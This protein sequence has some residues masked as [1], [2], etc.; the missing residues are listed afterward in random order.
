MV[1]AA[2]AL[3]LHIDLHR[4][5]TGIFL[6][7]DAFTQLSR[8]QR[9]KRTL[10]CRVAGHV[11]QIE[12]AIATGFVVLALGIALCKI[13]VRCER[14]WRQATCYCSKLLDIGEAIATLIDDFLSRALSLV[15]LS[16]DDLV[17]TGNNAVQLSL[18][19]FALFERPAFAIGAGID[20][21]IS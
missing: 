17:A 3:V 15:F 9:K 14:T 1:L 19:A 10:P 8:C 20:R 13:A 2:W 7:R 6:F 12:I 21:L 18:G 5:Q 16:R 4:A 11:E